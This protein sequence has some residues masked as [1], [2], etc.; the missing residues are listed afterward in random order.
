MA[1]PSAARLIRRQLGSRSVYFSAPAEHTAVNALPDKMKM[2]S[3][4]LGAAAE[5]KTHR[6]PGM[7]ID[8]GMRFD[9][10]SG[11]SS[12]SYCLF[13]FNLPLAS[14]KLSAVVNS[15]AG[16]AT[17]IEYSG[18]GISASPIASSRASS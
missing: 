9:F 17:S 18:A 13:V 2:A 4:W 15:G 11:S 14:A 1:L 5:P 6:G 3:L 16:A 12:S 7:L 8:S 10:H